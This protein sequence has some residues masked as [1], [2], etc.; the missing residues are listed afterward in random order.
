MKRILWSVAM[1]L[2]ITFSSTASWSGSRR[3]SDIP[4]KKNTTPL[5]KQAF[6]VTP[7][8]TTCKCGD[9]VCKSVETHANCPSDCPCNG[10]GTCNR[11]SGERNYNCPGDCPIDSIVCGDGYLEGTE[12]CD[13]GN[14]SD[15]DGCR[16]DCF[17]EVLCFGGGHPPA[18]L[19]TCCSSNIDCD[20]RYFNRFPGSYTCVLGSAGGHYCQET[21][22]LGSCTSDTD[23]EG[24][25]CDQPT[26]TFHC[27]AG[28]CQGYTAVSPHTTD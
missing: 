7:P 5:L 19:E 6:P 3:S 25:F 14:T 1:I 27:M 13:D 10:D 22:D 4:T 23:C 8:P 28:C 17:P 16:H 26:G 9:G 15:G 24:R 11:D 12:Q 20:S 2:T 18:A 21:C